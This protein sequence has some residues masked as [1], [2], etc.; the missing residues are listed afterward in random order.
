VMDD[1]VERETLPLGW[2]EAVDDDG[3]KIWVDNYNRTT[4]LVHPNDI[5]AAAEPSSDNDGYKWI[6]EVAGRKGISY[7]SDGV[8]DSPNGVFVYGSSGSLWTT[9]EQRCTEYITNGHNSTAGWADA[10]PYNLLVVSEKPPPAI[11]SASVTRTLAASESLAAAQQAFEAAEAQQRSTYT[12][13]ESNLQRIAQQEENVRK[14]CEP[15]HVN[16][17]L[18][19]LEA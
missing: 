14:N 7:P 15:L 9:R 6:N 8:N 5:F 10:E 11:F 19:P 1:E 17:I 16:K 2:V 12:H 3:R 4:S 18:A 13:I